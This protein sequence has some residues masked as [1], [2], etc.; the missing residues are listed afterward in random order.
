ML[1]KSHSS[2]TLSEFHL[3]STRGWQV[4]DLDP[5]PYVTGLLSL[6]DIEH[7][8]LQRRTAPVTDRDNL[9]DILENDSERE[10]AARSFVSHL[11][12]EGDPMRPNEDAGRSEF[13]GSHQSEFDHSSVR[14]TSAVHMRSADVR[15]KREKRCLSHNKNTNNVF[16]AV[17][18]ADWL[19]T[20]T[21]MS[22]KLGSA[23][24]NPG[25]LSRMLANWLIPCFVVEIVI[26]QNFQSGQDSHVRQVKAFALKDAFDLA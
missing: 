6:W 26:T 10:D 8:I 7:P 4:L 1:E 14:E 3:S 23:V 5:L 2:Q 13:E 20:S 19:E 9:R 11:D 17:C 12:E 24:D 21:L 25:A 16:A 22:S 18:A 15:D